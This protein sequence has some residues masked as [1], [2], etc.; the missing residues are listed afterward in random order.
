MPTESTNPGIQP[1]LRQSGIE[2]LGELSW[3]S[4]FCNFFESKEDLLQILVPYFNAGL[5]NN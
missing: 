4:H 3:G 2:I 5:I 1:E